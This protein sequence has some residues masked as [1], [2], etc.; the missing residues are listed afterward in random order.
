MQVSTFV[1]GRRD[2]TVAENAMVANKAVSTEEVFILGGSERGSRG[3]GV[4]NTIECD[5]A[6]LA[7]VWLNMMKL[8]S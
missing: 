7:I 8:V 5:S 3:L 4:T 1:L 6:L 2:S